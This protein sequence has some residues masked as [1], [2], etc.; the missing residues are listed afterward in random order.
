MSLNILNNGLVIGT[1]LVEDIQVVIFHRMAEVRINAARL[2]KI[3]A[4]IEE[5][6]FN[7]SFS[8]I[9]PCP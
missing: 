2:L 8:K 1:R 4:K 9:S 3:F 6:A 5:K 7:L